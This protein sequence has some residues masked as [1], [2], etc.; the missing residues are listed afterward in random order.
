MWEERTTPIG[1]MAL[2]QQIGGKLPEP[3]TQSYIA[4]RSR[5]TR[6]T[7]T[8]TIE[9]FPPDYATDGSLK[10]N[11]RFAFKY[12]ALDLRILYTTLKAMGGKAIEEWVR[13]EPTSAFSRRAWF[14]Y[15]YFSG[16]TLDLASLKAV[17]YVDM[18]DTKR[19]FVAISV[20]SPRHGIRN[21]L[22]GSPDLCPILRRTTTL[23]AAI[24]RR[25]NQRIVEVTSPYAP[26][27]LSRAIHFLHTRETRSSFAIEGEVLTPN[28]EERFLHV[29]RQVADFHPNSKEDILR[30]QR[31]IVDPRYAAND[32]RDFQNFVGETTRGFGVYVHFICPR[33]EDVPSLMQGWMALT[34]RVV[35]SPDLDPVLAAALSAFAFVFIHPFEDGNGRIHRYLIH[36]ILARRGYTPPGVI[37]PISSA[38]L[39]Q[40]H[41]YNAALES[42]SRPLLR[43]TD[44]YFNQEQ[45]VCVTN[46]THDLYRFF[47]ATVQAEYLYARLEETLTT[48]FP[49][50]L[51]FLER[52][53]RA[54]QAV[55]TIVDMP[56]AR[57]RVLIQFCYQNQGH[58]SK[59]KR[60]HFP[61]LTD[62]EVS[63]IEERLQA[64]LH[65]SHDSPVR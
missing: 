47:D 64:I 36:H 37:L 59:S 62:E 65:D 27:L 25:L 23:E 7:P 34:T 29:L 56:D 32:W 10:E 40:R 12:E 43:A 3:Y 6:E 24:Q 44:W 13:S 4:P 19:H 16:Q 28:R 17:P 1:Q 63:R 45:S 51:Q 60:S 55:R 54:M 35:N 39:R 5:H 15:E 49:D 14:C 21:N 52:F 9:F 11:L 20:N 53:D 18:L 38:M 61:E 33:P 31:A 30:L 41:L 50:E 26:D 48:D 46:D 57:S 8:A 42:F 2:H 22:L 58:L